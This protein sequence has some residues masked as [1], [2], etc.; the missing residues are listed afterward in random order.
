MITDPVQVDRISG[1]TTTGH[2][3]DGI[4]ELNTPLP[5]WWLYLFYLTIVFAFG[6]WIVY[7]SWPL[8]SSLCA[9]PV[10]NHQPQPGRRG[11]RGRDRRRACRWRRGW[12][13]R[14]SAQIVADPKLLEIALAEGKAAF[15]DNCAPCHG[16]GGQGQKGYP[17]LTAGRW[18]WGGTLDADPDDDHPRHSRRR[19]GHAHERDAVLR[20][21]RHPEAGP[22]PRGRQLRADPQRPRARAGRRRRRRQEDLRRQLRRL[23]R[24]GRQGQHWTW[25]RPT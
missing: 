21:G 19:S 9:R 5:R 2:E 8:V 12:R 13:R 23:P 4:R 18:L 15:G 10:R 7:P 14:A 24:R 22:D 16:S 25:A 17:N 1:Q 20:Q 3:W 6:Y 11:Y